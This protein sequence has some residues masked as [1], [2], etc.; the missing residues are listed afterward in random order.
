[1]EQIKGG[2]DFSALASRYSDDAGT[3]SRGGDLGFFRRGRMEPAFEEVAFALKPGEVSGLVETSYGYHIIKVEARR[4]AAVKPLSEVRP[5][6]EKT[7]TLDKKREAVDRYVT[8]AMKKAGAELD[9]RAL[10]GDDPH[11]AK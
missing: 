8:K 6:I 3:K 5:M 7:L 9:V 4:D 10:V 11:F 2:A 1:M